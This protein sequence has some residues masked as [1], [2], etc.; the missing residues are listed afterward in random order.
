[1][2]FF[3]FLSFI[4]C[5]FIPIWLNF[6]KASKRAKQAS[7]NSFFFFFFFLFVCALFGHG[8]DVNIRASLLE[9]ELELVGS[10]TWY[11][12]TVIK[13]AFSSQL[14]GYSILYG[15]IRFDS[16]S[17]FSRSCYVTKVISYLSLSLILSVFCSFI[18]PCIMLVDRFVEY[19]SEWMEDDDKYNT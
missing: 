3:S 5:D 7:I 15:P 13:R 11:Y 6:K 1:M 12:G 8:R 9:L 2:L 4:H 19:G 18:L 16:I 10:D 14:V 17:G